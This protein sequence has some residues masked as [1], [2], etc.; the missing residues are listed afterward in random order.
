MIGTATLVVADVWQDDIV[1]DG[2]LAEF[3]LLASFLLSWGFIRTSAHMIPRAGE[4]VAGQP[5]R[6]GHPRPPHGVRHPRG[7]VL[8]LHRPRL[9]AGVAVAGD[10]CGRVRDRDGPHARRVRAVA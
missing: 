8:R 5:V 2:K 7:A 4:V 3:L 6:E 1:G 9:R 10:L